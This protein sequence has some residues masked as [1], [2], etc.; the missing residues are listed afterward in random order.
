MSP[1][2]I[3]LLLLLVGAIGTILFW[4]LA[5][6]LA[7]A[8]GAGLLLVLN[9]IWWLVTRPIVWP[10]MAIR[11]LVNGGPMGQSRPAYVPS[12]PIQ[13]DVAHDIHDRADRL[14]RL[15]ALMDSGALSQAEF[16]RMKAEVLG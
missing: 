2:L 7:M 5:A 4:A 14:S 8:I 1:E 6:S 9:F 16:D 13:A 10:I 12:L 15:K 3:F 11:R